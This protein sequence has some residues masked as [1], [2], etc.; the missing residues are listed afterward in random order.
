MTREPMRYRL[1]LPVGLWFLASWTCVPASAACVDRQAD[2]EASEGDEEP[3]AQLAG[4][5]GKPGRA[6]AKA[7]AAAAG[8]P[9]SEP[10]HEF[11]STHG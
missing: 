1:S 2:A 11:P 9:L 4:S 3:L 10:Q 7:A 8:A 6:A 5:R